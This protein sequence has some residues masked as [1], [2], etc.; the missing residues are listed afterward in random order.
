MKLI[1]DISFLW[2]TFGS[3]KKSAILLFLIILASAI[4]ETLSLG[5]ILPFLDIIIN[6]NTSSNEG[7]FFLNL[8]DYF[9]KEYHFLIICGIALSLIVIKNFFS[10]VNTYYTTIFITGLRRY[11]S[12]EIMKTYMYTKF[13]SLTRQKQGVLLNNMINEPS[14]ASKALRDLIDFVAKIILSLSIIILLFAVSW[15]ITI[16]VSIISIGIMLMVWQV[17]HKYSLAVGKKKIKLNQQIS[18]IAAESIS[19][20]RQIKTFSM[21]NLIIREF[22]NK[23]DTLFGVIVRFTIMSSLPRVFGE[24]IVIV[25]VIAIL[26]YYRY[27]V[28]T[29]VASIIPLVG[30]F[31]ISAQRLFDNLSTLLSQRMSILS[32]VPSLKLVN[33]VVNDNSVLEK[34]DGGKQAG[35]IKNN[36]LFNDVSFFYENGKPLFDKLNIEIRKGY[37][38]AIAGPSGSGKS[39]I[40]DLIIGFYKPLSGGILVDNTNLQEYNIQSWRSRIGYVS[41][42]PFLFNLTVRENIII[43]KPDA[44]DEEVL[45]AAKQASANEFIESLP[46]QYNTIVGDSG[47]GI[48]GGQRQRIAIARALIRNPELLILDE[49]TSSLD[50]ESELVILELLKKSRGT[51]T[52]LIITHRL[53][54]LEFAD[55][56]YVLDKGTMVETGRY[57][58]LNK[59]RGLFWKLEQI[60]RRKFEESYGTVEG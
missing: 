22:F 39:T 16:I 19:G 42:D 21:E 56:I 51:K 57:E 36:I 8:L 45:L 49:A 27:K 38:T 58:E 55:Q 31:L 2:S 1:S 41:Q 7:N 50:S 3:Y 28:D 10:L 5:I 60:S 54:S 23:L 9:S 47:I 11:W 25:M 43:G 32:Y 34:M 13:P 44:S 4:T 15:R 12:S 29:S 30:F 26:V 18:G 6:P 52:I 40:C 59:K 37:I 20:I 33:T 48:S 24:L 17:T 53:S 14:F 35:V 46:E